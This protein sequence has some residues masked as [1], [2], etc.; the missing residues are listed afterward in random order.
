MGRAAGHTGQDPPQFRVD[1]DQNG[2]A[3]AAAHTVNCAFDDV[4]RR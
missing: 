4:E 1:C 3:I 2:G